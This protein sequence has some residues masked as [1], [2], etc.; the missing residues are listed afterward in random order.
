MHLSKTQRARIRDVR[1]QIKSGELPQATPGRGQR[2]ARRARIAKS[3]ARYNKE[4]ASRRAPRKLRERFAKL[5]RRLQALGVAG[6]KSPAYTSL[7]R[8]AAELGMRILLHRG[9]R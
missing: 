3:T 7:R 5:T 4:V 9:A 8:E 6:Q 1:A 2:R